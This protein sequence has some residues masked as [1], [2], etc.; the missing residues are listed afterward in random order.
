MDGNQHT[1]T[2]QYDALNRVG[3]IL[4]PDNTSKSFTYDFRGNKLTEVDQLGRTTKYV[5]DLAGQMTRVTYA[6][7]T[8]DAG[9][10]SY[11]YDLDGRRKTA[12]DE[13]SDST[14]NTYDD[15]GRLTSVQDA[16]TNTTSYGYDA[17][18]RQTSVSDANT[19]ATSY[20][21]DARGR[22]TTTTYPIIPPA[23]TATSSM[24]TYDGMGRLLMATDE[25]GNATTRGYD[26]VGRITSVMDA[27]HNITRYG[28]DPAGNLTSLQDTA[29]RTTTYQY[30]AR[31]RRKTRT[32]PLHQAESY[33]YD[34][35]GNL[36]TKTDFNGKKTTYSYDTLNRLLSKVPDSSLSQPTVSFTYTGTGQRATMTDASGPTT[37]TFDNRDRVLSKATPEGTL[38]YTYDAH[39]NV[40][41]IAS[42]N[43]NGA[44][45]TYVYDALNRLSSATDNRI[46]AQGAAA[47]K[48]T[49]GYDAVGN[50]VNYTYPSTIQTSATFDPLNRVSQMSSSNSGNV[51][52]SYA[53]TLNAVGM[54]LS[55]AEQNGRTAAYGYD[56]DYRLTSEAVTNDPGGK[57][58]TANYMYDLVGNRTQQTSTL[59]GITGGSFSYDANDRLTTD[60]YDN[61]G[62][63]VASGG[64]TYAYDFENRLL[65]SGGLG[66]VYDGDGNRV[67]ETVGG[68]T[69][70]YL[71]DTL[72]PTGLPQ[73]LDE[74]VSG[75]VTRTYSYG[76]QRIGENQLIS[77]SWT[78]S[79]YD[80]DGHGNVRSLTNLGGAVTDTY[81]YDAFGNPIATTGSTP[82]N[83]YF[84]GERLDS[85]FGLYDM[86][87]RYYRQTTG[88][89]W[90]RD[91]VEGLLC[92]GLSWNPYIYTKDNPVN[93]IDP[94]GLQDEEEYA[95]LDSSFSRYV[96]E[97]RAL[98]QVASRRRICLAALIKAATNGWDTATM[99]EWYFVCLARQAAPFN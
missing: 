28:Y 14:M 93:G 54:R 32:L 77:S 91:P 96:R 43:S 62:N 71:M 44:S 27:L 2:Y 53:Y 65:A 52:A 49:Y 66:L 22:L 84:S 5:Y 15:A 80:Y 74:I 98:G 16:L 31:N 61:N 81:Q 41:T 51:L 87:G 85:G 75:S 25:A 58:G 21:Y 24:A 45:V 55:A 36:A 3:A 67:A 9:T 18:N 78:P 11:T 17:D 57:N 50:L 34:P 4:Y 26:L 60:A 8:P 40:L 68:V 92:C 63:T 38:S 79:F 19:H 70:K 46:V 20:T 59:S 30:D 47:G 95:F 6:Y 1:T 94:T 73:V 42:S 99:A 97:I 12:T 48:T 86:R 76:L 37:Y 10:I 35:V 33:T 89:F 72:N 7:G 83:Y 64:L 90:N 82:N 29:Q 69:T 23:T 13:L 88:R 56:N 39:G